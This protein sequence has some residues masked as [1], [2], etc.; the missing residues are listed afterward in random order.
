M[1]LNIIAC[2]V[3]LF[4]Y[5]PSI[6]VRFDKSGIALPKGNDRTMMYIFGI[7]NIFCMIFQSSFYSDTVY[8]VW[9]ILMIAL[10]VIYYILYFRFFST[11][12]KKLLY[13]KQKIN[14]PTVWIEILIPLASGVIMTSPI[15]IFSSIVYGF[16]RYR[17][18]RGIQKQMRLQSHLIYFQPLCLD[19]HWSF[20]GRGLIDLF[21][22]F[23]MVL[24]FIQAARNA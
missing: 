5:I 21:R 12:D 20:V 15:L 16:M 3:L 23:K 7:V 19:I 6:I 24:A 10:L 9:L 17:L 4:L 11:K 8:M 1:S 18:Y 22:E 2:F 13:G 14:L